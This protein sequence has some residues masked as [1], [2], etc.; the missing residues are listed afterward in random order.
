LRRAEELKRERNRYCSYIY[1]GSYGEDREEPPVALPA[2][3]GLPDDLVA[4]L[5]DV[6]NDYRVENERLDRLEAER[7]QVPAELEVSD[8]WSGVHADE[9]GVELGHRASTEKSSEGRD[10][11]P[12][13]REVA[14]NVVGVAT[15]AAARGIQEKRQVPAPTVQQLAATRE[16]QGVRRRSSASLPPRISS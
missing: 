8:S 4:G 11:S 1:G 6:I 12:F 7:A 10:I 16:L 14:R 13:E 9:S 15:L 3:G 2:V 5:Q